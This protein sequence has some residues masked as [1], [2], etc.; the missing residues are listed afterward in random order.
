MANKGANKQEAA[1]YGVLVRVSLKG[2]LLFALFV[3][4]T[5]RSGSSR[6]KRQC[7]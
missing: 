5:A 6:W 3:R 7:I 1:L 2:C 4:F